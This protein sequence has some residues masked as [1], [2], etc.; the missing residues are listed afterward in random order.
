MDLVKNIQIQLAQALTQAANRAKEA[1]ALRFT[2]LPAF[3]IEVP[4]EKE[5]GDFASNLAMLLTRQA[6]M[7]P[8][9]IAAVLLQYLPQDGTWIRETEIA[10]AGFINFRLDQAWLHQVLLAVVT[11]DLRYGWVPG[12][13]TGV[14]VE[15]VSANPTGLLHMGNARG[16]ALGDTIANLLTAAGYQVTREFYINDTGNQI[17]NFTLS[18]EARYLQALGQEVAF[19]ED[20]YHGQDLVE[21]VRRF[22]DQEGGQYLNADSVLRRDMLGRFALAEKLDNIKEVLEQFGVHYDVWFSEQQLHVSGA[23]RETIAALQEKGYLYELE[24]AW[25]F[26]STAFGDEKD[27]VVVRSNGTPTYFAADLAYHRNKFARGFDRVINIWGADHHGHVARLHMGLQALGFNPDRTQ[28]ILMQLVR[29]YQGGEI[30]RMSKRTGQYITL[31]E[32]IDEVGTDAA[33]Y[34]FLMRSADS[35]L[36]FDL[37]LAKSQTNENPVYYVQ[38]AHA[39]VCSIIRQAKASGVALPAAQA[40]NFSLLREEAEL[41]LIRKIADLPS[42]I[43]GAAEVLEPHRLPHYAHELAS[44]FHGFY[45]VCRVL[46]DD[47]ALRDARL[48][49]VDAT[50]ITLRNVLT[51]LGIAAPEQM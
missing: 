4:R 27:E 18:L 46:L 24:G 28:I 1:G 45:T 3:V 11:E 50:R 20:G 38:Y 5:H 9:A 48:V 43:A 23:V 17:E 21:T 8:R 16:A 41:A 34:F 30:L 33:R 19:P 31:N 36:D 35:H 49:L 15:F 25:W 12:P 39:R 22:I 6:K 29:L 2:A 13:G 51:I 42:V 37:D 40:V 14:Q 7:N 10:G 32:L 26:K 47:P 44:L